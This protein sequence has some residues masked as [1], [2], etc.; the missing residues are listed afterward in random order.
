M[1]SERSRQ[2]GTNDKDSWSGWKK[3][4]KALTLLFCLKHSFLLEMYNSLGLSGICV[5][6]LETYFLI[7]SFFPSFCLP[8]CACRQMH[9]YLCILL[10]CLMFVKECNT[11]S[12]SRKVLAIPCM[13]TPI[14]LPWTEH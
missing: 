6:N 10:S 8:I 2:T 12:N 13:T 14:C 1:E 3:T 9:L 4:K 7:S 5:V 11:E